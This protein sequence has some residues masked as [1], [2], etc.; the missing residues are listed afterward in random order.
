MIIKF[1]TNNKQFKGTAIKKISEHQVQVCLPYDEEYYEG[2]FEVYKDDGQTLIGDYSSFIYA[3]NS[4][5]LF[6]DVLEEPSEQPSEPSLRETVDTLNTELINTQIAL[7]ESYEQNLSLTEELTSMQLA[8]AE[9]YEMMLTN[10]S[11]GD[12]E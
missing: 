2:G 9:L 6:S 3:L 1:L 7:A 10:D 4:E 12:T 5:G 11:G 8:V